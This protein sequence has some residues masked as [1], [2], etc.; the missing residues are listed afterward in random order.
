M[1]ATSRELR[2]PCCA[3]SPRSPSQSQRELGA[4]TPHRSCCSCPWL[5]GL[6]SYEEYRPV[7]APRASDECFGQHAGLHCTLA[8]QISLLGSSDG[9]QAEAGHVCWQHQ[10]R[11]FSSLLRG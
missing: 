10:A 4:L 3:M 6:P 9:V 11:A 8:R 5:A 7:P 1:G 2:R